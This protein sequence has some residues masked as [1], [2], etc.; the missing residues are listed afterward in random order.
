MSQLQ[1]LLNNNKAW[2]ERITSEDADFFRRLAEQQRPEYLWIG[3]SDSRVPASQ[4][5]DLK[6]GDVFVHRNIANLV[7]TSD[8]N[9]QAVI[10]FAVETL[11]VKHIIVCGHYGCGGVLAAMQPE[12]GGLVDYWVWSIKLTRQK[13]AHWFNML[14]KDKQPDVLCELNVIEQAVVLSQN[15][16]IQRHWLA[17][18][19]LYLHAWIYRIHD[20]HLCDLDFNCGP[21][22][23]PDT[24]YQAAI[25]KIKH[26]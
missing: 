5:V 21:G 17:G 6:P 15:K 23:D 22:E 8:V 20:G 12:S 24:A 10:Q 25:A 3:C 26:A 18:Q 9:C 7:Q 4:V 11:K 13:H 16:I 19:A 14:P 2:A 1:N